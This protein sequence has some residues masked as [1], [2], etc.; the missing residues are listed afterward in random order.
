MSHIWM[1]ENCSFIGHPTPCLLAT[2]VTSEYVSKSG[3]EQVRTDGRT[4]CI[5]H[6]TRTSIRGAAASGHLGTVIGFRSDEAA[7]FVNLCHFSSYSCCKVLIQDFLIKVVYIPCL[8]VN[9]S[10]SSFSRSHDP[11]ASN[12]TLHTK[13]IWHHWRFN[14]WKDIKTHRPR[15]EI[16]GDQLVHF[17]RKIQ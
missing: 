14:T 7:L 6:C 8:K 17:W 4:A 10:H 5:K 12:V 3:C 9:Q 13:P 15:P 2:L 16:K 1:S 11:E